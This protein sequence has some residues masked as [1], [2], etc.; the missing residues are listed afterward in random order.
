MTNLEKAL[1]FARKLQRGEAP[2]T[3]LHVYKQ[4]ILTLAKELERIHC[5]AL[6]A[7]LNAAVVVEQSHE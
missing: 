2:R 4:H 1:H 3:Y 5:E 6:K 7:E